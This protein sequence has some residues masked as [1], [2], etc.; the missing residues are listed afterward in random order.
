MT[1][2]GFEIIW[3]HFWFH[4]VEKLRTG[5]EYE[6]KCGI[7]GMADG[8]PNLATA[9]RSM[10]AALSKAGSL[11]GAGSVTIMVEVV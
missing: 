6:F 1:H 3:Q 11:N 9:N 7:R 4:V 8:T 2:R 5:H 10:I